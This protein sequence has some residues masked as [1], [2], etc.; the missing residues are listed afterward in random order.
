MQNRPIV[1]FVVPLHYVNFVIGSE[2]VVT[3]IHACAVFRLNF[4]SYVAN[5]DCFKIVAIGNES[6][7]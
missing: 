6:D 5:R 2:S 4:M 7:V 3:T 1:C